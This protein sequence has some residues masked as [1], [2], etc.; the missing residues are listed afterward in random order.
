VASATVSGCL[1]NDVQQ[2]NRRSAIQKGDAIVVVGVGIDTVTPSPGFSFSLD[3]FSMKTRKSTGNCFHYNHIEVQL[4]LPSNQ[5]SVRYFA[6]KVPEGVYVWSAFNGRS[7][8]GTPSFIASSG[9]AVYVCDYVYVSDQAIDRRSNLTA[10]QVAMEPVLPKDWRLV[11][12][13]VPAETIHGTPFL[14]TP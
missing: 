2:I 1:V 9:K 7:A 6:Y 4:P 12:A 5:S 10:A 3:E 8:P 14:C 13:D 11:T